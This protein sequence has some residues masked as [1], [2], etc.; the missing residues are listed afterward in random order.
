MI[1]TKLFNH[2]SDRSLRLNYDVRSTF[3]WVDELPRNVLWLPTNLLSVHGTELEHECD[4]E[5]LINLSQHETISLFRLF[6]KGESDLLQTILQIMVRDEFSEGFDYFSHFVEEENK[7]MWFFAEFCRRYG[8]PEMPIKIIKF[9]PTFPPPVERFLAISRIFLFEELGD[10]FNV[11]TMDDERIPELIREIHK[12]HHMD[13]AGHMAAGWSIAD[14]MW[15]SLVTS[16]EPMVLK[17]AVDNLYSYLDWSVQN[18]YNPEAYRRA[19]FKECYETRNTLLAHPGR[20]SIHNA[21]YRKSKIKLG[22]LFGEEF[23]KT[24]N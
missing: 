5:T 19:G 13:E 20:Q 21:I 17:A 24:L 1:D 2:L 6:V 11:G 23:G 12:R 14:T 22:R 16:E 4:Q 15:K 8:G 9:N 18:L 7:H 3:N 10:W